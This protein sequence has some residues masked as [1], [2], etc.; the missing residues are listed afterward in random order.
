MALLHLPASQA[1]VPQHELDFDIPAGYLSATLIEIGRRSGVIV[2]FRPELV[3]TRSARSIQGRFSLQ[4]VLIQALRNTNLSADIKPDGA[5]TVLAPPPSARGEAG[6]VT[7]GE[8]AP[9]DGGALSAVVVRAS[10]EPEAESDAGF[11][12]ASVTT[13]TRTETALSR[14]PLAVS[15]V[16]RDAL[17]LQNA[18]TN[19]EA[20]LNVPGV[21]AQIRETSAAMM[22]KLAIRGFPAQHLLSGMRTYRND[23]P[24]DT[25]TLERIEI[26]KGPSGVVGGS[27]EF[28]GRG[29][30]INLVRKRA[31]PD[32]LNTVALGLSSRDNGTL[33]SSFDLGAPLDLDT[34]WR[35]IGYGTRSGHTEGGY[36]GP[37]SRG[38]LG[39]VSHRG[40][41]LQATLTV[42]G[43]RRRDV[44][45][46]ASRV[47][48]SPE[49]GAPVG[50]GGEA[51][52]LSSEDRTLSDAG[53]IE[54]DL[55]WRFSPKWRSTLKVR[56]EGIRG[57]VRRHVFTED[58]TAP[59]A[60]LSLQHTS[61][62]SSGLQA[63]VIGDVATGPVAHQLMLAV[64]VERSRT[65]MSQGSAT[66]ALDPATF[67][68]GQTALS[69]V[70][71]EG[72]RFALQPLCV[73]RVLRRGLLLQDQLSWGD[74]SARLAMQ[75]SRVSAREEISSDGAT[76]T[77]PKALNW[78]A[79]LAYQL[80]PFTAVY[81]G[82]QSA[83]AWDY[84]S[85]HPMPLFDGTAPSIP[86]MR[87]VQAGVKFDLLGDRLALTLEA[88]RLQ[89]L[90]AVDY[91]HDLGGYFEHAGRDVRGLEVE[92]K[93]HVLTQLEVSFGLALTH[94]R[95]AANGT[96]VPTRQAG[97]PSRTVNLLARYRL[98]ETM[99]PASSVGL[100][101]H[102]FSSLRSVAPNA[103]GT[104]SPLRLPGGARTDLS[105][106]RKSGSWA[107]GLAVQNLFD[108]K[109]YG[110][111]S[112]Q[113]FIPLQPGRSF[114]V[115]LAFAS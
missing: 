55:A 94:A 3:S 90:D 14:L 28:G 33:R 102:A 24:F 97:I 48:L 50:V 78:D 54:L 18:Q 89:Q 115:T 63:G 9:V 79:G 40:R 35:L 107:L 47:F 111:Y 41:D 69:D 61:I 23:R 104:A 92:M 112:T 68:P 72:D 53:D 7:T 73:T 31:G 4:D 98:P 27:A 109:L 34:H 67:Q 46:G 2:S 59:A 15:V 17:D 88:F 45:S 70:P 56:R 8:R 108:R 11:L 22:P 83:V 110:T 105:W 82:W 26:L 36:D 21:T 64:D 99:L 75:Q 96:L 106:T 81:G 80:T 6:P 30:T 100:A 85:A 93:G 114:G 86:K 87:Q 101:L 13:P 1:A 37:H 38:L 66:W 57:D 25:E 5:V 51:H 84:W 42:H 60:A 103:E 113:G 19:T 71:D 16:T 44:P 43:D 10:H 77:W 29:G 39:T 95:D 12:A 52:V 58:E 74:W 65:A 91:S 62:R 32:H 49:T 20:L 76:F